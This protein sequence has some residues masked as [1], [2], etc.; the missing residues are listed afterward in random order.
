MTVGNSLKRFRNEFGLTQKQIA[1]SIKIFPQLYYK[2]ESDKSVPSAEVILKIADA[3]DVSTDY[4]LGRSDNPKTSEISDAD[5]KLLE[6]AKA[7]R[8]VL[9][10]P[11]AI[12]ER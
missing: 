9:Q 7:F 1:D 8:G 3:Y 11:T 12:N 2:Y 6:V 4:L 10:S 5:K